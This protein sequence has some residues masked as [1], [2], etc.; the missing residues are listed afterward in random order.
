MFFWNSFAF[1]LIQWQFFL[2]Y[3]ILFFNFT[4]LYWFCHIS[5]WLLHRYTRGVTHPEP[6]S[7]LPPHTIPMGHPSTPASSIQYR[8]SNLNWWLISYMILYMF[9]MAIWS[10]V[11]LPFLNPACTSGS[12]QFTYCWRILYLKDFEHNLTSMWNEHSCTVV[13]IFLGLEW[14]LTFSSPVSTVEFSKF[15]DTLSAEL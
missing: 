12:S 3:F 8:A 14:K 11:P 4:I 10:L 13:W 2:I 1:S 15:A 6:S 9:P 7:L 5:T